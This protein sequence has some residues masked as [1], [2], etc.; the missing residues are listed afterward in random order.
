MKPKSPRLTYLAAAPA[1][2][3]EFALFC[4]LLVAAFVHDFAV[5]F[6]NTMILGQSV[7]EQVKNEESR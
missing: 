5:T 2:C 3:F 1:A 4:G 7:E 6:W